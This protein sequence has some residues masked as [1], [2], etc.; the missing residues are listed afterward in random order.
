MSSRR[1]TFVEAAVG[2]CKAYGGFKT[3]NSNK[4]EINVK[5]GAGGQNL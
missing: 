5:M 1:C 3:T 2:L 4:P